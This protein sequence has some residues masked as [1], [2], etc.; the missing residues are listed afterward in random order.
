MNN[1]MTIKGNIA[2]IRTFDNATIVNVAQNIRKQTIYHAVF[3]YNEMAKT[4]AE[5]TVG[6]FIRVD[7]FLGTQ[8]VKVDGKTHTYPKVIGQKVQVLHAK[9][10]QNTQA[11]A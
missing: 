1:T 4:M 7:G 3:F 6:D 8:Q 5:R 11:A 2:S 10:V 9:V